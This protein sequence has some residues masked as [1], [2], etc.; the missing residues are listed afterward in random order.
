MTDEHVRADAAARLGAPE[1]AVT[2]SRHEQLFSSTT[3]GFPGM[4]GAAMTTAEV[5]SATVAGGGACVYVAARL[6]YLV[7]EPNETF[8]LDLAGRQ[9]LPA[10]SYKGQYDQQPQPAEDLFKLKESTRPATSFRAAIDAA[11]DRARPGYGYKR[12]AKPATVVRAS[13][14][15]VICQVTPV[16][17]GSR[18]PEF[19]FTPEARPYQFNGRFPLIG[20]LE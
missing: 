10:S 13:D 9:L 2:V 15:A 17:D 11:Y 16:E 6:C 20:E 3:C 5:V 18:S 19:A 14:G 4:G 12:T 8:E 1:D 7:R